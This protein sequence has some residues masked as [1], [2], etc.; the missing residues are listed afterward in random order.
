MRFRT[1]LLAGA[2]LLASF[3]VSFT[4]AD[5]VRPR[6]LGEPDRRPEGERARPGGGYRDVRR[7]HGDR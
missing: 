3:Q 6:V 2:L 5:T 1:V 4:Q 7:L